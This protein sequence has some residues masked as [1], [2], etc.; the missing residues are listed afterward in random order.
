MGGGLDNGL[1]E[2]LEKIM[3]LDFNKVQRL[4][5]EKVKADEG[6]RLRPVDVSFVVEP[7]YLLQGN[8]IVRFL[9]FGQDFS[10]GHISEK[11]KEYDLLKDCYSR[12]HD[13]DADSPKWHIWR[14]KT[15]SLEERYEWQIEKIR[16][17]V[18]TLSQDLKPDDIQIG[19]E[20]LSGEPDSDGFRKYA[21]CIYMKG[22]EKIRQLLPESDY[23]MG[24]SAEIIERLDWL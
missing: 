2:F 3:Q 12:L 7:D 17:H 18:E 15:R 8:T 5:I 19:I 9:V 1:I 4:F 20:E 24:L 14:L 11:E 10:H 22:E 16:Q 21:L 13:Y 6:I 23:Q